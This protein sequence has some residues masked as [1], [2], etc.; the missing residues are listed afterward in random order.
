M[1]SAAEIARL[2][3][4]ETW[5][6]RRASGSDDGRLSANSVDGEYWGEHDLGWAK[7]SLTAEKSIRESS[8]ESAAKKRNRQQESSH[9]QSFFQAQKFQQYQERLPLDLIA[10]VRDINRLHLQMKLPLKGMLA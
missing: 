3:R 8:S 4:S 9:R 10:E 5:K 6:Q 7:G 1:P 2:A